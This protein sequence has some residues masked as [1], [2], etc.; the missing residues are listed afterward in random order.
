MYTSYE[1][2]IMD[3]INS[4]DV[5][6]Q[7]FFFFYSASFYGY[8][9]N[10]SI[11]IFSLLKIITTHYTSENKDIWTLQNIIYIWF[12]EKLVMNQC[13]KCMNHTNVIH[14]LNKN[15]FIVHTEMSSAKI[16]MNLKL[17]Y[18]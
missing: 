16:E 8:K 13:Q 3:V 2:Y 10:L 17:W 4:M 5:K 14:N 6:Q 12:H 15:I 7:V 1:L 18:T 11:I 9:Y